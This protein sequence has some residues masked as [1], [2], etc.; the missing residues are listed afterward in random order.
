MAQEFRLE[1]DLERGHFCQSQVPD[2]EY[3]GLLRT[4]ETEKHSLN[5]DLDTGKILQITERNN[6]RKGPFFSPVRTL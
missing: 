1:R 6:Q 5:A 3:F 4:G 2:W